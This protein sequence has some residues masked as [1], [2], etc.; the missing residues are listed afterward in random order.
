M[1]LEYG[2]EFGERLLLALRDNVSCGHG[3]APFV[4]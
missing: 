1:P 2:R 3:R 4:S